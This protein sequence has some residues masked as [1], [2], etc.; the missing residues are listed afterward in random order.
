[1]LIR[2][3]IGCLI[4]S[5]IMLLL[6]ALLDVVH[7]R[8]QRWARVDASEVDAYLEWINCKMAAEDPQTDRQGY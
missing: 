6:S 7:E 4:G 3:F 2:F 5:A 8:L 1:M